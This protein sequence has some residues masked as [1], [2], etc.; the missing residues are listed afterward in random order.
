MEDRSYYDREV[1][2]PRQSAPWMYPAAI[3][4]LVIVLIFGLVVFMIF[5]PTLF[6]SH[7]I[8]AGHG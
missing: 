7:F 2:R 5:K 1:K 8:S 6:L 3:A 4:V